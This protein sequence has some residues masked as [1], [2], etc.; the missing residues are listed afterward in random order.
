M[1]TLTKRVGKLV[2]VRV[3]SPV[4]V[5]ETLAFTKEIRALVQPMERFVAGADFSRVLIF[6]PEVFG[7]YVDCMQSLNEKVERTAILTPH[8]ATAELQLGRLVRD[9]GS[10]RRRAFR[11]STQVKLW[12]SEVLTIPEQIRLQEFLSG[13]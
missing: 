10:A 6:T 5:E 9:A 11:S 2:E 4:T 12:L 8:S 3:V 1:Y 13:V 7:A